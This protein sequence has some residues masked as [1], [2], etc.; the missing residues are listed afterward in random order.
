MRQPDFFEEW[1]VFEETPPCVVAI[2]HHRDTIAWPDGH[3][4]DGR[5]CPCR[6]QVIFSRKLRIANG[7]KVNS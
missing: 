7:V 5:P 1:D 4:F 3:R 6:P 2:L